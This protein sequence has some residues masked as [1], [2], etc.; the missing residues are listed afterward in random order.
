MDASFLYDFPRQ[1]REGDSVSVEIPGTVQL[2]YRGMDGRLQTAACRWEGKT[3]FPADQSVS[4]LIHQG[5]CPM[6]AVQFG[7]KEITVQTDMTIRIMA[8]G[9]SGIPMVTALELGEEQEPDA[10]RPS[11]I[12]RRAE[13]VSLW[14]LAK[15]CGSTVESIKR[16]NGLQEEPQPWQMLLIPVR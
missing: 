16:A 10:Q 15:Q 1:Y 13:G 12:L 14:E 3:V 7:E 4:A 8:V 6:S 5:G 2:L 11:L 9:G